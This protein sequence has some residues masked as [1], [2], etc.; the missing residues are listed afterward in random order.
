LRPKWECLC[1]QR[2]LSSSHSTNGY[3]TKH[4]ADVTVSHSIVGAI[5]GAA[6]ASIGAD[7]V[8]WGWN[9]GSGVSGIIAAWFIAPAIAGAF[10][11]IV[12]LIT[13]YA[14][15]ERKR[16]LRNG[17]LMVPVYF[18]V[19]AGVL[20]MVI[21]WKGGQYIYRPACKRTGLMKR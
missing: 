18:A 19:T 7:Q 10:A 21:V 8:Q 16:S 14:V 12:F 15:L 1:R 11:S 9:K 6:I 20:T 4:Y 2:A 13:K 3:Q 5:I 17:F